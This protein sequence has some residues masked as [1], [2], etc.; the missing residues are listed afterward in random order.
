MV[1]RDVFETK[2]VINTEVFFSTVDS[3]LR[4]QNTLRLDVDRVV[5]I[6]LHDFRERIGL[7]IERCRFF[8]R[9]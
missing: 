6:C 1:E 3:L 9:S 2:Q 8:G 7:R 4:Q 5:F